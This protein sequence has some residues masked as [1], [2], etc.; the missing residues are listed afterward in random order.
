MGIDIK[1]SQIA[2][3]KANQAALDL[4]RL[5]KEQESLIS[6]TKAAASH[7]KES[8]VLLALAALPIDRLKDATEESVRIETLRKYGFSNVASIYNSSA[9]QLE[10]LPGI[11]L[12]S[13][14]LLKALADQIYQAVAQSISY[15]IDIDDLDKTDIALIENL[16]GLYSL[17]LATKNSSSK[18]EPIAKNIRSH[19]LDTRTPEVWV[20]VAI[21]LSKEGE[22]NG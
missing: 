21:A 17:R 5:L 3:Q 1:Q 7:A 14:Q 2:L 22:V 12:E 15:G 4:E 18:M 8:Q 20:N 10:R 11:T 13:A 16:Q 9:I 19:L 6:G